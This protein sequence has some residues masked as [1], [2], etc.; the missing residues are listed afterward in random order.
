MHLPA[1]SEFIF[2]SFNHR[3]LAGLA[4]ARM[5][6]LGT[7]PCEVPA[8]KFSGIGY[9]P[10][11]GQ[12]QLISAGVGLASAAVNTWLSQINLAHDADTATT[13]IVNGLA[14]L[15]Q[16][17]VNAYLAGPGTCADQAAAMSAYLTGVRWLM[18]PA[19]C[20]NGAYGS[21]GNR[22]IS[23]RFGGGGATDPNATFPWANYYYYPIANDPRAASCTA[24]AQGTDAA[25]ESA[26]Q[27]IQNLVSGSDVQTV[28]TSFSSNA[29][30]N[31]STTT[32]A[33]NSI[34]GSASADLAS[35][36]TSLTSGTVQIG[37]TAVPTIALVG[38]G[39]L[40]LVMT[41]SGRH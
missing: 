5:L 15:L 30:Q 40:I 7:C 26:L 14:P 25:E 19:G 13:Q 28:P 41:M 33:S 8:V 24:A 22:C 29:L 36:A 20:G 3:T 32:G 12:A 2:D 11:I 6:S 16:A 18:S 31:A 27:N 10:G 34:T 17:N 39:L 23:D 9:R 35:L 1:T 37:S 4:G 38:A 21:A